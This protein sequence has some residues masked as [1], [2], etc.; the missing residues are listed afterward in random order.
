LGPVVAF[1]SSTDVDEALALAND[2]KYDLV[3]GMVAENVDTAMR[4]A[5][6]LESGNIRLN[7]GSQWLADLMS[8]GCLK[9]SGFGREGTRY[10]VEEMSGLKMPC[11]HLKN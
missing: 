2:S 5:K 6:E 10:A 7:R 8:C 3:A 11:F 4:F 1:T 9:E